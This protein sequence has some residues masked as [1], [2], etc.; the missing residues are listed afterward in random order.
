[1]NRGYTLLAVQDL[2]IA[3]ASDEVVSRAV[4]GLNFEVR[5]GETVCLVGESGCG[6]T[7]SSLAVLGLIPQPPGRIEHGSIRF[8]GRELLG[9]PEPALRTLRGKAISMIF[10]D[11]LTSLNP[12]F[13][14][15]EQIQETILAHESIETKA[16]EQRLL[17]LIASVGLPSPETTLASYPHQLSGGQRQRVMIAMAMACN[18]ALIIADEPTTALDVTVQDQ[19]IQLFRSSVQDGSRSILYITHDL[20]VVANLAQRVYVMYAGL[21]VEQG[22]AGSL[23]ANPLHPY[24]RGLLASLPGTAKRGSLL[25]SIPGTVPDPSRRPAGCPFHPRCA[26]REDTCSRQ[27]PPLEACGEGHF[28][29]CPILVHSPPGMQGS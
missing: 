5:T 22:P 26:L 16:L 21:I 2:H 14:V 7:V 3:F 13:T 29:R 23:F 17:T 4:V 27:L 25:P 10:Q 11:P 15:K 28:S 18:P 6:K 19:I 1:M 20:G 24:T 9:L 12:V 8:Q